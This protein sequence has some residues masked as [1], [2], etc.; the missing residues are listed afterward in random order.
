[1]AGSLSRF[2]LALWQRSVENTPP[3]ARAL[4][5]FFLFYV[6]HM[7]TYG[8]E[9]ILATSTVNKYIQ[10]SNHMW[11]SRVAAVYSLSDPIAYKFSEGRHASRNLYLHGTCTCSARFRC[12]C[13]F[14]GMLSYERMRLAAA[15]CAAPSRQALFSIR[16]AMLSVDN[17]YIYTHELNPQIAQSRVIHTQQAPLMFLS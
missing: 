16:L 5:T 15:N 2:K 11:Q 13:G 3:L 14:G 9:W 12:G 8:Y 1:M 10:N 7:Q 6:K 17:E 4:L